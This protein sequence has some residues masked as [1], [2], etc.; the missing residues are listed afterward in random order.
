MDAGNSAQ[1]VDHNGHEYY[2]VKTF[3]YLKNKTTQTIYRLIDKGN[4]VRKLKAIRVCGKP[5]I[6]IEELTDFP[7]VAPGPKGSAYAHQAKE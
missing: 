5:L 6:P 7:F 2:E 1:T 3:A 4:S